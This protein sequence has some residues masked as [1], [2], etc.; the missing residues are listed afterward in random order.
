MSD[1]VEVLPP[2]EQRGRL[3]IRD[4]AVETIARAAAATV[5]DRHQA[6]G[7]SRITSSDLPRA[8]VEVDAGQ[9]V[10]TLTVAA[11]WPTPVAALA[12]SVRDVVTQQIRDDTGLTVTR[13]DV[14]VHCIPLDDPTAHRRVR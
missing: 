2:P 14:E 9:V 5:S 11:Q 12:R 6:T 3:D 10:V 4:G 13:V 1:L 8:R 7:L